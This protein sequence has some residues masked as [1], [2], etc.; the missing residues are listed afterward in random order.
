MFWNK[1]DDENSLPDINSQSRPFKD[2][3]DD[4]EDE[5]Q[6]DSF[7][8]PIESIKTSEK[9][10]LPSFPDSPMKK[11]FSQSAIKDAI[12][13]DSLKRD[14]P[15]EE[16]IPLPPKEESIMTKDNLDDINEMVKPLQSD[17]KIQE[18]NSFIQSNPFLSSP[19]EEENKEPDI[20]QKI[21]EQTT[22]TKEIKMISLPEDRPRPPTQKE[23][24]PVPKLIP[25]IK[26]HK[27]YSEHQ[28]YP[29]EEKSTDVF[30]KIDKFYAAKK[31]INSISND[32]KEIETLL[33]RIRETK[34]REERELASW[35]ENIESVK[36]SI[37]NVG[38]NLFDK[39]A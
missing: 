21:K 27:D 35:E 26:E 17:K 13:Q 10:S 11:G 15:K 7:D 33:S 23:K 20:V 38:E 22:P 18:R 4:N 9:Q 37:K 14:K 29:K 19:I 6:G 5:S 1:K 28:S 25:K 3:L 8:D 39:A 31:S 32:I 24:N 12:S 16:K 2:N 36:N 34:M 30:V